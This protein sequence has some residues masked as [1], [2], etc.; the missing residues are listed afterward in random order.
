MRIL[1]VDDSSFARGIIINE[2]NSM[3]INGS[4]IQQCDNGQDALDK[5]D[6][7]NFDLLMLD[8]HMPGIDGITVL[9]EIRQRQPEVNV[10]I[11]SSHRSKDTIKDLIDLG[12]R[13]FLVK[14]FSSEEFKKV[15]SRFMNVE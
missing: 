11:C 12:A 10:V 2:L 15:V 8:V 6:A 9:K 5:I 13:D 14:P 3:G 4:R 7:E 1:V